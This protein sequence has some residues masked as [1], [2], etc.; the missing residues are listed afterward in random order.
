MRTKLFLVPADDR[1]LVLEANEQAVQKLET[2]E[3]LE[4]I[5]LKGKVVD[6]A[7]VLNMKDGQVVSISL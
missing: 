6:H 2:G 4:S 1:I 7:I 5:P 3:E